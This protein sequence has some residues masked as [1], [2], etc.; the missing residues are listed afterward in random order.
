[1]SKLKC[2]KC[3]HKTIKGHNFCPH[4]GFMIVKP[5]INF[6]RSLGERKSRPSR[7]RVDEAF[8][9]LG[10]DEKMMKEQGLTKE[11]ILSELSG[12]VRPREEVTIGGQKE[13]EA[14]VLP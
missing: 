12:G 3:Q 5:Q 11:K 10:L 4:C 2:P 7:S 6:S 14:G 9:N 13:I 8:N 1:M